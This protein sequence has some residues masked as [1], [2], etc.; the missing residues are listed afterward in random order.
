M[1]IFVAHV[2]YRITKD[3]VCKKL[4]IAIFEQYN[5]LYYSSG[6]LDTIFC[7]CSSFEYLQI[8]LFIDYSVF[9]EKYDG[10]C[11]GIFNGKRYFT[12]PNMKGLFI[13]AIACRPDKRFSDDHSSASVNSV[14]DHGFNNV[15]TFP[16]VQ[17]DYGS[18]EQSKGD[19]GVLIYH[20]KNMSISVS[21]LYL[22]RYMA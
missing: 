11:D 2:S 15:A 12:C 22:F 7:P 1:S 8:I 19:R 21:P 5:K 9:Q 20:V 4:S 17:A 10:L 16:K 6:N 3:R 18:R 13:K 14:D